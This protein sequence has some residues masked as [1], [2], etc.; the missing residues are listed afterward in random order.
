MELLL[1][2][3]PFLCSVSRV[4][5]DILL[6]FI[7]CAQGLRKP[8]WLVILPISLAEELELEARYLLHYAVP[9]SHMYLPLLHHAYYSSVIAV[10]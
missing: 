1:C 7:M 5:E 3:E 9:P 10:L 6:I 2:V 4:C 8:T